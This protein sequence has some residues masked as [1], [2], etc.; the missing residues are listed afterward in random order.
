MGPQLI[1][2]V[3]RMGIGGGL[4]AHFHL[5][6]PGIDQVVK[7]PENKGRQSISITRMGFLRGGITFL[8]PLNN[9]TPLPVAR[10]NSAIY[11]SGSGC[12]Y[13]PTPGKTIEAK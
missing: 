8:T 6:L 4:A 10:T 2:K 5:R 3:K 13:W 7:P 11:C 12:T 9:Q 1:G